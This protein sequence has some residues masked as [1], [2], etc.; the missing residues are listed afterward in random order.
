MIFLP[1]VDILIGTNFW[2]LLANLSLFSYEVE[3]IQDRLQ[4]NNEKK[5]R[6]RLIFLQF[7]YIDDVLSLNNPTFSEHL[8]QIYPIKLENKET[9]GLTKCALYLD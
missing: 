7:C 5:L 8:V 3:C 4:R 9:T 1:T 6:N 2:R